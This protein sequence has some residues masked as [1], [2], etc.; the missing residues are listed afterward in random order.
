[1]CRPAND[2]VN[3]LWTD[4]L[5]PTVLVM[6]VKTAL[7]DGKHEFEIARPVRAIDDREDPGPQ[8]SREVPRVIA[9]GL[10]RL[11]RHDRR[12][13][14]R[15][16]KQLKNLRARGRVALVS[17]PHREPEIDDGDMDRVRP[18]G[19]GRFITGLGPE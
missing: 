2:D 9:M 13:R 16:P 3:W 15:T 11:D 1:M 18:D 5:G 17:A 19:F 7:Q 14:V 6:T 4:A 12:R 10:T 8:G